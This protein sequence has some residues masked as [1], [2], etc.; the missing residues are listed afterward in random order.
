MC[1]DSRPTPGGGCKIGSN[2]SG[3]GGCEISCGI[4]FSLFASR[5]GGAQSFTGRHLSRNPVAQTSSRDAVAHVCSCSSFIVSADFGPCARGLRGSPERTAEL[6]FRGGRSF[7]GQSARR[8]QHNNYRP[9]AD[10]NPFH[11]SDFRSCWEM[12]AS[13]VANSINFNF[14]R[15]R[16]VR[17]KR[18]SSSGDI[19]FR[20][21][22]NAG[23]GF[24]GL[25]RLRMHQI[26]RNSGLAVPQS[27]AAAAV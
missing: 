8:T 1:A 20:S 21:R 24:R 13:H 4:G 10:P 26:R 27:R 23:D 5:G 2:L 18:R 25:A 19:D 15:T 9:I 12:L 16:P 6:R 11:F 7:V 14:G 17:G 22:P 3:G